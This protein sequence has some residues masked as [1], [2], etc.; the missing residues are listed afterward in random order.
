MIIRIKINDNIIVIITWI[1]ICDIFTSD[2]CISV[3]F[4]LASDDGYYKWI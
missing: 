1:K 3:N 2:P 4:E